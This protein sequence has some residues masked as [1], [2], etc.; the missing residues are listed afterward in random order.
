MLSF[1]LRS[2]MIGVATAAILLFAFPNLR[3]SITPE[4]NTIEQTSQNS[5]QISFNYAVRR[6]APAVVNIYSRKYNDND[7]LRLDTEGLGSG[8]SLAIKAT[9]LLTIT[10]LP[11]QTKL[12][13]PFKM[14]V[15]LTLN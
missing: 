12:L 2:A 9:L 14:D 10:L 6:A 1:L 5:K 4:Q 8:V 11:M 7:R 15:Y 13:L 3:S